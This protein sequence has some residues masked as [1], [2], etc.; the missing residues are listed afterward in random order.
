[1]TEIDHWL[2]RLYW[3]AMISVPLLTIWAGRIVLRH[4]QTVSQQ[5]DAALQEAQTSKLFKILQYVEEQSFSDARRIVMTEIHPHEQEGKNWW[6]TDERLERAAVQVCVSYDQLAGIVKFDGPDRVGQYFLENWGEGVIRAHNI[7]ERFLVSR[8]E[9]ASN[10][11]EN[12]TWLCEQA[13][14][15]Q[16]SQLEQH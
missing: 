1:M 14:S 6:K 11:Y 9:S 2:E 12:F 15:S 3:V 7:L 5:I 16:S 4:S 8:R 13:T 10:S